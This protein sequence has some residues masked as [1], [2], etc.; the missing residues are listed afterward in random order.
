[1]NSIIS[2]PGLIVWEIILI[3][4][5]LFLGVILGYIQRQNQQRAW[6]EFAVQVGLTFDSG[7]Y[8]G[9][10]IIV[11]GNYQGHSIVLDTSTRW[12]FR[13]HQ[14]FTRIS[15]TVNNSDGLIFSIYGENIYGQIWK[16]MEEPD[17]KVGDP[18]IDQRFVIKS[19][20]EG[21]IQNLLSSASLKQKLLN[22]PTSKINLINISLDG[23]ELQYVQPSVEKQIDRLQ[24]L[25]SL[26]NDF[27]VRIERS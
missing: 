18:A 5:V 17:I 21:V 26:L 1:M 6:R 22:I 9:S 15:M 12:V 13:H 19:N 20:S 8:L 3:S 10:P 14:I 4:G 27:A 7:S 11:S 2:P 23:M 24:E 16:W 25:F